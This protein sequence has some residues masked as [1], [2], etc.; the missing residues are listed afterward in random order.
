MYFFLTA[1]LPMETVPSLPAA[2]QQAGTRQGPPARGPKAVPAASGRD[3][4]TN[5]NKIGK[6]SLHF[7]FLC[8]ATTF[9]LTYINIYT[10]NIKNIS[11]RGE[12]LF[13]GKFLSSLDSVELCI[14]ILIIIKFDIANVC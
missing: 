13:D 4:V 14:K 3:K 5:N 8:T 2:Q 12:R 1:H 9:I 7:Y 10:C 11:D 6:T